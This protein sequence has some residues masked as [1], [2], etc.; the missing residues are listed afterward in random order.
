MTADLNAL[1]R[2]PF[3]G[4]PKVGFSPDSAR[5]DHWIECAVCG[6][7]TRITDDKSEARELWNRR[8]LT[9]ATPPSEPLYCFVCNQPAYCRSNSLCNFTGSE[10]QA[11]TPPVT[12]A[13]SAEGESVG[14]EDVR[15]LIGEITAAIALKKTHP[16][17]IHLNNDIALLER[18]KIALLRPSDGWNRDMSKVPRDVSHID[19]SCPRCGSLGYC[20]LPDCPAPP[21]PEAGHE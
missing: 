8:A 16:R 4:S 18:V 1:A 21:S 19:A 20:T 15:E 7:S 13:A 3:C 17:M 12:Q 2:C 14:M 10:L 9:A 6:S 11:T 5:G